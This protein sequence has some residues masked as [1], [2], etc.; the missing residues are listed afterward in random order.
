MTMGRPVLYDDPEEFQ[1][2]A[3]AYFLA[4][5]T[6]DP[7]RR[8]TVNGLGLALGMTRETLL[9]YEEKPDFSDA[10]KFVRMRLEDA[11]EQGL[12]GPNATGT[13]FWL[14]NQGW[15]DRNE[16]AI[17]GAN[18]GPLETVTKIHLVAGNG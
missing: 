2:V 12:S 1:R 9:R 16:T 13:I 7:P 18:G 3:A 11:W 4:C 6:S 15:S 5:D 10:V 17:T 8:P 14:K